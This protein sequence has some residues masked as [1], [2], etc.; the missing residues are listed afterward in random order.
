MATAQG[1][2]ETSTATQSARKKFWQLQMFCNYVHQWSCISTDWIHL[3]SIHERLKAAVKEIFFPQMYWVS[4]FT[5][6]T[7]ASYLNT[8]KYRLLYQGYAGCHKQAA[9]CCSGKIIFAFKADLLPLLIPSGPTEMRKR[10]QTLHEQLT[11]SFH[12]WF[13]TFMDYMEHLMS[14][15]RRL[16][17]TLSHP[18]TS[19]VTWT[20]MNFPVSG[21]FTPA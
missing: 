17:Q 1:F 14:Q 4:T 5:A 15:S 8:W 6:A 20:A 16:T 2:V 21:C 18:Q 12:L 13:L 19:W 3:L 7:F 10:P 11:V 9:G